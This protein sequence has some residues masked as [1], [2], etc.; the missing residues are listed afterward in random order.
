MPTGHVGP[1]RADRTERS[2]AEL[3][4]ARS[5][6]DTLQ[7]VADGV[8]SG[9]GYR[10]AAVNLAR[11]DGDLVVAALAGSPE[12]E[13]LITGRVG[14]RASWERRL[15]MGED[16][17][18]LRFIPH[19]EGWILDDDDV[20]QWQTEI[21]V[22]D[23][24]D[25]WHPHDRLYA[26]MY[27]SNGELS[28][29][30][31]VDHPADGRRPD[32]DSRAALRTYAFHSAIALANARL[33]SNMQRALV[34][35]E[36]EQQ[37]LRAS[38]ESFRQSFEYAPS[39]IAIAEM[40]GDLHGR[41]LR[42]NDALCRL[43]E[44][45]A[46]MLRRYSL[47][48][49]V[50]PED[51]GLLLQT[52]A[53]GG[54]TDLRLRRRDGTF[55]WVSLRNSVVADAADGPRFLLTHLQDISARKSREM[56]LLRRATRDE[57]TG[58]LS[59]SEL[60]VQ[61][62]DHLCYSVDTTEVR[63]IPFVSPSRGVSYPFGDDQHKHRRMPTRDRATLAVVRLGLDGFKT[64]NA[65]HGRAAGDTALREIA[66]GLLGEL[67]S[68][69]GDGALGRAQCDEFVLLAPD[70]DTREAAEL[71]ARLHAA[72]RRRAISVTG[73]VCWATCGHTAKQV[74]QWSGELLHERKLKR[75][76][77]GRY[78]LPTEPSDRRS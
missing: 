8:V 37:A 71:E 64:F 25:G 11:P 75:A 74:L 13:A 44:R 36:R 28:G 51:I 9:L 55:V 59:E 17:D 6:A 42:A 29:V 3:Y 69:G 22:P 73:I 12:A 4:T 18:G 49:L 34:R 48:D 7:A 63:L 35:L 21:S 56:G 14:S 58:L 60:Q 5:L 31:S 50:H 66:N 33:R 76:A 10:L 1:P 40:G 53:E 30:I 54:Q 47:T 16:W 27:S 70:V 67:Q 62:E 15:G 26:P 39:G 46:S 77:G 2:V 57:L 45:P 19:T 65:E 52:S 23:A 20:P 68:W 41:L 32:G 72:C 43:L 38:E 61:L 24:E 78:V